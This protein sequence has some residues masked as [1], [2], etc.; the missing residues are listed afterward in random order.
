MD[1]T[2]TQAELDQI[3]AKRVAEEQAKHTKALAEMQADI[4]KRELAHHT[5]TTMA[6]KNL[7]DWLLEGLNAGDK[8]A[9]D[10]SVSLVERHLK[11][12]YEPYLKKAID[13]RLRGTSIPKGTHYQAPPAPDKSEG[14]RAAM[15]L[16]S[17]G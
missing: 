13:D 8:E 9:F 2:F 17:K 14:I 1:K 6:A 4:A 5:K 16:Q 3:I 10:K 7:P 11:E 12:A 15:G